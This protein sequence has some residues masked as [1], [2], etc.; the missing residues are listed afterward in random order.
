[1]RQYIGVR[2]AQYSYIDSS[3]QENINTYDSLIPNIFTV[4]PYFASWMAHTCI[5][6]YKTTCQYFIIGFQVFDYQLSLL[7]KRSYKL[8]KSM[9]AKMLLI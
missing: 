2:I 3:I 6:N 8:T 9:R 5:S 7:L 4:V 1:M